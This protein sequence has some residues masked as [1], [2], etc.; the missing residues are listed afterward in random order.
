MNHNHD[1]TIKFDSRLE[2]QVFDSFIE[3]GIQ[4]RRGT[5]RVIGNPD[6]INEESK[7]AVFVHGCYWHRHSRCRQGRLHPTK[8]AIKW[9]NSFS[10]TVRRDTRTRAQLRLSGWSVVI[11]WECHISKNVDYASKVVWD[12]MMSQKF[13]AEI[14]CLRISNER[15]DI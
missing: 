11:L 13:Q 5:R 4:L 15:R 2:A 10:G 1:S 12:L 8:N 6:F 3:H 9:A 14:G 7:I